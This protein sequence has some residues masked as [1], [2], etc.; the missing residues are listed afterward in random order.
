MNSSLITEIKPFRSAPLLGF[1]YPACLSNELA[2]GSLKGTVLLGLPILVCKTSHGAVAAMR[3][4]CP[5]RGM[6]LSFGKM[7]GDCVQCA[8]HGWRFDQEGRCRGIPA[9]VEGSPSTKSA[10]PPML[11]AN[12]T[13]M[14]GCL[15]PILNDRIRPFQMCR[16]FRS[17]RLPI[18]WFTFRRYWIAPSTT[19]SSA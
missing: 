8:Y 13:A 6:P 7:E 4:I 19:A 18:G 11:A 16:L 3:D 15:F 1:W 9:L 14:Y 5:H 12:G 2:P 10:S 17:L